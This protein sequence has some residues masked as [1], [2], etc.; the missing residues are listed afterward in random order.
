[1][2]IGVI[3]PQPVHHFSLRIEGIEKA[4]ADAGYNII[5]AQRQRIPPAGSEKGYF[6]LVARVCGVTAPLA[7]DTSP[8]R[9]LPGAAEQRYSH[10]LY[11][12]I[13]TGLK[14]ERVV[15]TTMPA[16][17]QPWNTDDT[18]RMQAYPYAWLPTSRLPRIAGTVTRMP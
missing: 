12:R 10:R 11:D 3:V 1:M 2:P 15:V 6:G 5:V 13:C 9:P 17:L 16:P 14:T 8:I 18:D 7:K 4:A